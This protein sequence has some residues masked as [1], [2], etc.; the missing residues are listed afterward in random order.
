MKLKIVCLLI[1]Q[2]AISRAGIA[3]NFIKMGEPAPELKVKWLKGEPI[4]SFEKGRVYMVEFWATWCKPCIANMPHLSELSRK[5][6]DK[7]VSVI[8]VNL[9]IA[10]NLSADSLLRFITKMGD[11]MDYLV[12]MD[13]RDNFMQEKWMKRSGSNGVPT[14]FIVD[15]KGNIAWTGHPYFADSILNEIV[16]GTNSYENVEKT[17]KRDVPPKWDSPWNDKIAEKATRFRYLIYQGK[18]QQVLKEWDLI[19]KTD[20]STAAGLVNRRLVALMHVDFKKALVYYKELLAKQDPSCLEISTYEVSEQ[21]G[22]PEAFYQLAK[23]F[24]T[25]TLR[26]KDNPMLSGFG[27]AAVNYNLGEPKKA[28][29]FFSYELAKFAVNGGAHMTNSIEYNERRLA[30][31]KGYYPEMQEDLRSKPLQKLTSLDDQ[32]NKIGI[33]SKHSS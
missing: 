4:K 28:I 32:F 24:L 10:D 12:A 29:D 14:S 16:R 21:Y 26:N 17:L 22:L 3:Q 20:P 8:G 11:K 33:S 18:Y 2:I 7:N 5:Y 6:K 1:A 13:G 15:Q 9:N 19:N 25:E 27:L 23:E 31:Y 30:R